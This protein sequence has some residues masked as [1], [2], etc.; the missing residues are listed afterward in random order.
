MKQ[1]ERLV[2]E[3]FVL[4]YIQLVEELEQYTGYLQLNE[5][6]EQLRDKAMK[7]LKK[8]AKKMKKALKNGEKPDNV[9]RVKKIIEK[10]GADEVSYRIRLKP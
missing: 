6:A 2:I 7:I 1:K 10:S 8:K 3:S 5:E 9:L 4:N